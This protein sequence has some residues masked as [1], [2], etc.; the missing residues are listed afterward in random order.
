MNE[1]NFCYWLKGFMEIQNPK[2]LDA[3]QVQEIKNHLDLVFLKVTPE[4]NNIT[5]EEKRY[6]SC[7]GS[8]LPIMY[9]SNIIPKNEVVMDLKYVNITC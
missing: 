2:T 4:L 8:E 3:K 1:L 5:V 7:A 9:C 6:C